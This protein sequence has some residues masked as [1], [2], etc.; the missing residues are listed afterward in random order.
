[1]CPSRMRSDAS[2]VVA[3]AATFAATLLLT[4]CGGSKNTSS[5]A[6]TATSATA[7]T[8]TGTSARTAPSTTSPTQSSR[9][10]GEVAPGVVSGSSGAFAASMHAAGHHPHANKPWPISFIAT[11]AGKPAHAQVAY[12][13][14][15]AGQVVA[16]RSHY[17]FTGHFKDVFRWPSSAVGFPLTF[18]AVIEGAGATL[19]LDYAVQV[20]G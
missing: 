4:A 19:N 18:R 12:E 8:T 16:H 6:T 20:V 5:I 3:I 1:M 13:Y 14:L 17:K 11:D 9:G 7:T 15:F 10:S 2:L